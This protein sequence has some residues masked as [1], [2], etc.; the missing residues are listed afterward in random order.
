M[1][2][3]TNWKFREIQCLADLPKK[4]AADFDYI[5]AEEHYS[6]R[7]VH[8]RNAWYD[9]H[10]AQHITQRHAGDPTGHFDA[11]VSESYFS[12]VLFK[13]GADCENVLCARYWS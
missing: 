2:I 7:M 4:A 5:D 1:Q 3:I 8:Y 13:F 10:D 9:T 12:G 6:P 11:V